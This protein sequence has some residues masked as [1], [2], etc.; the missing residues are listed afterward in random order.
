M[1]NPAARDESITISVPGWIHEAITED[2][3]KKG[4]SIQTFIIQAIIKSITN[5]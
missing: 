2:S 1:S 4:S 5:K 3:K